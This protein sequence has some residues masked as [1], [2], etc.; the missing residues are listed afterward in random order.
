[1]LT[2][3]FWGWFY[4]SP[5]N[6]V[7]QTISERTN[8][9][10]VNFKPIEKHTGL[11]TVE[12]K[13]EVRDFYETVVLIPSFV[14]PPK[15]FISRPEDTPNYLSSYPL[16]VFDITTDSFKYDTSSSDMQGT[17]IYRARGKLLIE[18]RPN[19]QINAD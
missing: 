9:K 15:L 2:V 1:M 5:T 14:E 13:F 4:F 10:V 3:C 16:N 11:S 19:K 7:K 18:K 17:W 12:G 8:I 6:T